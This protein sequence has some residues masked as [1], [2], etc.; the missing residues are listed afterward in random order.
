MG[1]FGIESRQRIEVEEFGRMLLSCAG[2]NR[3]KLD[4]YRFPSTVETD[5]PQENLVCVTSGVSY[6]GVAI[7]N[8]LLL[9][10]YSVRVIIDNEGDLEKVREMQISGQMRGVDNT[11][12]VVMANL[13]EIQSLSEAFNGCLGVF[14]TAAFI[15]PAG[16][17]GYSKSKVEVEVKSTRN[18]IEACSATSS[19]RRCV[20][21]SSLLT[22]I[23]R[24][25]SHGD[26]SQIIDHTCWSDESICTVKKLWYALGKL[27]AEK[28]AIEAAN[29]T[30]LK[31]TTICTA[32]I[33]GPESHLRNSTPTIAYLKGAQEMYAKGL[34]AVVDVNNAAKAHVS[35]F[36]EMNRNAKGRYV[37]FDRLIQSQEEVQKLSQET[38]IDFGILNDVS[39]NSP[40]CFRLSNLKLSTLMSRVSKCNN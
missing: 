26:A 4:G 39:V 17:S 22:C 33:T 40:P 27:R 29:K 7:V 36:N 14:H 10:G 15:D 30:K 18:V 12:E 37:C 34:M 1:V 35:V 21:T 11:I 16:V 31:L 24:D 19:V 32:L 3:R 9:H 5:D 38:G 8:Q 20:L 2:A 25:G 23:W 6:L 28:S 13:A